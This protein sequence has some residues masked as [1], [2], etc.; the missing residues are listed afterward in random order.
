MTFTWMKF[1]LIINKL[2]KKNIL[3][4]WPV[5]F[6]VI[7]GVSVTMS[8]RPEVFCEKGVRKK[9]TKFKGKHL[10]QNLFFDKAGGLA[11]VFSCEFCETFKNTL[12]YH[13]WWLLLNNTIVKN[14]VIDVFCNFTAFIFIEKINHNSKK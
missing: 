14:S 7:L 9:L 4:R 2:M 8:S 11:Q 3:L 12:F 6:K 5:I 13:L 10:C 1:H